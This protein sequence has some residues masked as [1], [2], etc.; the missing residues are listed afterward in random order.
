MAQSGLS[1]E[2]RGAPGQLDETNCK[3]LRSN[4]AVENP[5]SPLGRGSD[6]TAWAEVI[7][8]LRPAI[9]ALKVT[10][11]RYFE[12]DQACTAVG[13]GFVVDHERGLI[14]TNRHITGVG[15]V[16]ASAIFD[17]HEELKVEAIYRDPIHDFG[18]F[19]F[20]PS[21]L[22]L[23]R[24]AE[25]PLDPQA[26]KIGTE[27]RVV[28]NDAGEKLQILSGTIARVDRNVPEFDTEYND[29]NTFYAGAGAGTSG[30]SSG[31]PVLNKHGFAIALNAAG[32][33]GAASAFFL[34]LDRVTYTLERIR[35][36]EPVP[37]GTLLSKFLFKPFDQLKRI[38]LRHEDELAVL[39]RL[40]D[41]TG[42]LVVD[43][44]VV[45][46]KALR[47]GD[48]LLR[49]ESKVCIDFAQMEAALDQRVG[50][51]IRVSVCRGGKEVELSLDVANLHSLI[52]QSFFE[53]GLD[54]IHELGYHAAK[55]YHV[56][57]R[58]GV[59]VS[60]AGYVFGALGDMD[61]ALITEVNGKKTTCL[62]DFL[63][64]LVDVPDHE[65]FAVSW[66]ELSNFFKDRTRK[67][68][69]AK[70]ARSWSPM[71]I[72]KCSGD[73]GFSHEW[74]AAVQ[75]LPKPSPA[76]TIAPVT[77]F[78]QEG[79]RALQVIQRSLV[80][81]SFRTDRRYSI[82]G[83]SGGS[84][85][86]VG[87]LLDAELGLILTDR[88]SVSQSLASIEVN[89]MGAATL[90]A[91]VWF[92]HPLHN[93]VMLKCDTSA[94]R[95]AKLPIRSASL[96]KPRNA[97]LRPGES[98]T[99]VGFDYQGN[100]FSLAV[101]IAA[102]YLPS[103]KDEF[104]MWDIPRFRQK[105][106]EIAVLADPPDDILGGVLCDSAGHVRALHAAFDG[107]NCSHEETTESFGIPVSV[108]RH[109]LEEC[110]E[111]TGSSPS[112]VPSLDVDFNAVDL[113]T[114]QRSSHGSLPKSWLAEVAQRRSVSAR[115]MQVL[116]VQRV[117]ATGSSH[118]V[119]H[120]GDIIM[121]VNGQVCLRSHE[122]EDALRRPAP[123]PKSNSRRKVKSTH[124]P[125][126]RV[127]VKVLRQGKE[128]TV[129]VAL[130][131][132]GSAEAKR[133]LCWCG[134]VLRETPR[135]VLERVGEDAAQF[136]TEVYAQGIVGGSPADTWQ[137][138]PLTCIK[139]INGVKISNLDDVLEALRPV[140]SAFVKHPSSWIRVEC[141]D[142]HGQQHIKALQYD[143]VF[144]P[145]LELQR[146]VSGTWSCKQC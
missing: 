36:G 62:N 124:G 7:E 120:S 94:L 137:F 75:P 17:R 23:T 136:L 115:K 65:Y 63:Q 86:G 58:S 133:L 117:L 24:S 52:P 30:G 123:D 1:A 11:V 33:E 16:R 39:Q 59:Y 129:S 118:G 61:A 15:P 139:D 81:I 101:T 135:K 64:A 69:F 43:H 85:E 5:Q 134:I 2:K 76:K 92:M 80:T 72:W 25:I 140:H 84:A 79:E 110:Q 10:N 26:L 131:M 60:H 87:L 102:V 109:L 127:Q 119:L 67:S 68:G 122:V 90:D 41:A 93:L 42:M 37:R 71:R 22:R 74:E 121:S 18:F 98:T 89:F 144:F 126:Q 108:W 40:P 97:D 51:E 105:N 6:S 143:P 130:S 57:M 28:G 78:L 91:H 13:T 77:P 35:K 88:H 9:V 112:V 83:T 96:A 49:V 21:D 103:G 53:L 3:R 125:P 19:R 20:N 100:L 73:G 8:C 95:K 104:P 14:L 31:S 47:P 4:G 46:Q 113:A 55:R 128:V 48:V 116:R 99:F 54:I 27:I 138:P 141:V 34:P 132:L 145:T 32:Q 107:Q 114:L 12:E 106:L 82:E 44:V 142:L 50:C 111:N 45:E 56:A 29:E 70:M 146:E 38:G 66:F